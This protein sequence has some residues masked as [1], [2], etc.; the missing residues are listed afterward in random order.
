L[1]ETKSRL[2]ADKAG[3]A[4]RTLILTIFT[5][6]VVIISLPLIEVK[7]QGLDPIYEYDGIPILPFAWALKWVEEY[8]YDWDKFREMGAFG[9]FGDDVGINEPRNQYRY[10]FEAGM[11]I[12]PFQSD[13]NYVA[14]NHIAKYSEGMYSIWE[15]EGTDPLDGEATLE[16]EENIGEKFYSVDGRNGIVTKPFAETDTLIWGPGYQQL[17]YF[18][19]EG[20]TVQYETKFNIM[21]DTNFAYQGNIPPVPGN[22]DEVCEIQATATEILYDQQNQRWY[23]GNVTVLNNAILKVEDFQNYDIWG[24]HTLNYILTGL[25]SGYLEEIKKVGGDQSRS[26]AWVA[27]QYI[28]FKI[29]WKEVDYLR[30]FVDKIWLYDERGNDL[31]TNNQRQEQ[32]RKQANNTSPEWRFPEE[33]FDTTV[34]AWYPVDEPIFIDQTEPVRFIDILIRDATNGS[35]RLIPTIAA[36][37]NGRYGSSPF[38]A[39]KLF[40]VDEFLK[41]TKLTGTKLNMYLYDW[42]Y[43]DNEPDY[44]VRNIENML[45]NHLARMNNFD[46]S[47]MLSMQTG[48]WEANSGLLEKIPTE[49]QFLYNLNVGLLYGAKSIELNSYFYWPNV[50][51]DKTSLFDMYNQEH[52]PLWFTIRDPVSPRLNGWFGK[53]LKKIQQ[54]EQYTK[55]ELP[56]QTVYNQY[57]QYIDHLNGEGPPSDYIELGFFEKGNEDYFMIV[58]RWYNGTI[59]GDSLVIGLDKTG[60]GYINW[61]VTN[62]IDST[63]HTI[64]QSGEVNMPHSAG[65]GRLFKVYPVVLDGGTLIA[66]D[67]VQGGI[68]LQND[69]TID[70]GATLTISGNYY[71]KGNI[72]IKN[73]S[74]VNGDNGKIIFEDG[75]KLKIE[76]TASINGTAQNKLVF[77]F[78]SPG[79]GETEY[80]IVV[81][82]GG[83]LSISYCEV[84]NAKTGI[85]AELNTHYLNVEYVDFND[86]I[87]SSINI[88]GQQSGAQQPGVT[89]PPRNQE[90]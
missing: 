67:T 85:T 45:D 83:S 44:A 52:Q 6:L 32:I 15:A 56:V 22:T 68:I 80:G 89:P 25:S 61:N 42:P 73:G 3:F 78:E 34:I 9:V 63:M 88:I 12:I 65:D 35:K 8:D 87:N 74:I 53:T 33:T 60:Q 5:T 21:I 70:N 31:F 4:G 49:S 66:N 39:D 58:S 41:R 20:D 84:N 76:G 43:N 57:L 59:P 18:L 16:Y 38:G 27:A 1:S 37:Y 40:K 71:A 81:E 50:V 48:L 75:K 64:V 29:L 7:A 86:C 30:L 28:E 79:S 10:L 69:M 51:P 23:K 47:F 19:I 2:S 62:F 26:T 17:V 24:D 14:I 13:N 36:S 82:S 11:K 55:L 77:E 54:T 72:I 46:A 90:L